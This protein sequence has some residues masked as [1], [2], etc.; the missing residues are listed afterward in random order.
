MHHR[1]LRLA[2]A[3]LVA[4]NAL[5]AMVLLLGTYR[6]GALIEAGWGGRFPLAWL[7]DTPSATIRCLP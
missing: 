3:A 7:R 4:L 5:S 6:D 2:I 1:L